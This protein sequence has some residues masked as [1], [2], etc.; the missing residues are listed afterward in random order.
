MR[1]LSIASSRRESRDKNKAFL[2]LA[3]ATNEGYRDRD[4]QEQ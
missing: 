3:L 2:A 4:P 1:Q